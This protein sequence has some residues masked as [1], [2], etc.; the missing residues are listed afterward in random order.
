MVLTVHPE[1][2]QVICNHGM[3][4]YPEE[5]CGLLVGR[6]FNGG[7]IL[8]E[9]WPAENAWSAE[10]SLAVSGEEEFSKKRRYEIPA[11]FMFEAQRKAR[12]LDLSI[13]GIYHSHPDNPAI[14]SECDRQYA[15]P[16]YSYIIVSV[17]QGKAQDLQSWSLDDAHQ[18]QPEEILTSEPTAVEQ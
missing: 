10:A 18:F 14:P 4:A 17:Q 11:Q 1:H 12:D 5:C 6:L 9:V 2:L 3:S 7:K 15:W 16:Q 13:I 8:V